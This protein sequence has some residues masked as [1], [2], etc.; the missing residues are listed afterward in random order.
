MNTVA[1][2][3]VDSA[4]HAELARRVRGALA[5]GDAVLPFSAQSESSVD[6]LCAQYPRVSDDIAVVIRTSGSTGNP[7]AVAL[8]AEAL[9]SSATATLKHLG[10]AGQWL[11]ALSPEVIAG[12]QMIV[13]SI[14]ADT[15]P[16]FTSPHVDPEV[17]IAS[18]ARLTHSRRYT[19]LVPVQLAR[20]L[21]AP[22]ILETLQRFD[23]ILLGGQKAPDALVERAD[24]AGIRVIQT[25]GSTE[26]AGGCAY[27]GGA[28]GDTRFRIHDGEL[29]VSGTC[30]ASGY[31]D[32][33]K[34]THERFV[35]EDNT[36]W[37]RTHDAASFR[38]GKLYIEGRLDNVIISGGIKVSLDALERFV[39]EA[40]GWSEAIA[41]PVDDETWG[42]RAMLVTTT[43]LTSTAVTFADLQ[44]QVRDR[45]GA[46][47]MP[48]EHRVVIG[49]PLLPSGKPDRQALAKKS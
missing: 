24:Q 9:T 1:L 46:A 44:A 21:D 28:L 2:T 20:L 15:E 31:L 22:N 48:I 16:V 36:R 29:W 17:F 35:R 18:A 3:A 7:R 40:S 25:Y 26:T 47:A 49:V 45:L 13:R 33:M 42:Q 5:G 39:H 11:V 23:A 19:A 27:D 14:V 32:D 12:A 10:G 41:I 37:F 34:L 43:R 4:N 30:L 38:D 6:K 8:S